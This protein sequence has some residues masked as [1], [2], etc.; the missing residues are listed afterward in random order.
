M[1]LCIGMSWSIVAFFMILKGAPALND[2]YKL[3]EKKANGSLELRTKVIGPVVG[4]A[5]AFGVV[6]AIITVFAFTLNPKFT[7]YCRKTEEEEMQEAKKKAEDKAA[8]G[9]DETSM[10][11][12]IKYLSSGFNQDVVSISDG[13]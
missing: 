2:E 5:F 13:A 3:Y 12:V 4:V 6:F 7:E 10:G 11:M 9:E 1:P 8:A